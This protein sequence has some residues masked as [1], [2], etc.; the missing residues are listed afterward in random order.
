MVQPHVV[1][2]ESRCGTS[3]V[4]LQSLSAAKAIYRT[5]AIGTT[6]LFGAV[7]VSSNARRASA[8]EWSPIYLE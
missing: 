7:V 4:G 8:S 1:A 3:R 5:V 6:L 2:A